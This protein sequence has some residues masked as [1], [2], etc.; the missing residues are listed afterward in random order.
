MNGQNMTMFCIVF[1]M[2]IMYEEIKYDKDNVCGEMILSQIV[3][4]SLVKKDLCFKIKE[5]K[6]IYSSKT[7][8]ESWQPE[9]PRYIFLAII[10]GFL[11]N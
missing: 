1:N 10:A 7:K 11:K 2:S 3:L 9:N 4:L 6:Q 8:A 5:L